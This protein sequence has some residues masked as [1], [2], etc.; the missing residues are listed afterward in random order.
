MGNVVGK[1]HRLAH[2]QTFP[3][4]KERARLKKAARPA[5]GEGSNHLER[6]GWR[7]NQTGT[8]EMCDISHVFVMA[9]AIPNTNWLDHCVTLDSKGFIKTG[10]IAVASIHQV[11]RE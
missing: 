3:G 11:L 10:S 9:G 2:Q 8:I 7:S 6:V 5:D 1:E 4:K